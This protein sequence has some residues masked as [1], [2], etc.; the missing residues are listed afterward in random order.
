M[1][2]LYTLYFNRLIIFDFTDCNL[3]N[4]NNINRESS[5]INFFNVRARKQNP[6]DWLVCWFRSRIRRCKISQRKSTA[7]AV[8]SSCTRSGK[9]KQVDRPDQ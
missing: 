3:I 1:T 2:N 9:N 8:Q 5:K 7:T 6:D 4:I